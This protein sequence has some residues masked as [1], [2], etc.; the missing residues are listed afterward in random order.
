MIAALISAIW[1]GILTSIS[2]C[3]LATN[4]AAVSY[5]SKNLSDKK[6]VTIS[7]IF[8]TLGRMAAY[9]LI[10]AVIV[11][12]VVS[13]PQLSHFLQVWGTKIIGPV[14]L[15]TGAFLLEFITIP[16]PSFGGQP[17]KPEKFGLFG[18]FLLGFV[19]AL[20]FCPVSAVLFFGSLI[21]LAVSV[22]SR[23]VLPLL[24][25]IGTALPVVFFAIL[26]AT[27]SSKIGTVFTHITK[28]EK[29]VR[30]TFGVI[31]IIF[32]L[33]YTISYVLLN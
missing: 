3:P 20:S 12:S 29:W 22:Q 11:I 28:I 5:I 4:I 17:I 26:I 23:F 6:S 32:G 15:L 33:Y 24:Y 7:S 25:G 27:G 21:P 18:S 9:T 30:T 8:Y 2:P 1:L 13:T 16:M 10:S 14:L 31:L 19:F